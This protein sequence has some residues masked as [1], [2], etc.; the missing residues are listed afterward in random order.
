MKKILVPIAALF[1]FAGVSYAEKT[2]E[3]EAHEGAHVIEP[4]QAHHFCEHVAPEYHINWIDLFGYKHHNHEE[5][6]KCIK[7]VE[8]FG[9]L[10]LP[11]Q[12]ANDGNPVKKPEVDAGLIEKGSEKYNAKIYRPKIS[13]PPYIAALFNF[14]I[15]IWIFERVLDSVVAAI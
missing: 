1:L 10:V 15:L 4:N 13:G 14:L 5:V 9:S 8:E 3:G 7:S 2:P 11:G 12:V 6:E